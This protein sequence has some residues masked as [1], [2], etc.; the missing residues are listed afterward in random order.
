MTRWLND[1]GCDA[2]HALDL[3]DGNRSTDEQIIQFAEQERRIV[4][5]KDADFVNSHL[6]S[7]R[8]AKLLLVS[9]GE[10]RQPGTGTTRDFP[11]AD[12]PR[13]ISNKRLRRVGLVGRNHPRLEHFAVIVP[14]ISNRHTESLPV[15]RKV[16]PQKL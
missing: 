14:L 15:F 11:D 13:G 5:T 3:P 2:T 9:T 6:L 7:G 10:H 4:V 12:A 8:P 1:A 16:Q